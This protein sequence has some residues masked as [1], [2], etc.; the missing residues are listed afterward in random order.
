M[1]VY[2]VT[3]N[4]RTYRIELE[5]ARPSSS[6]A[7][8]EQKSAKDRTHESQWKVLLDG[9]QLLV[10]CLRVSNDSLSLIV[11]G[12]SIEARFERKGESQQILTGGRTYECSVRDPRSFRSRKRSGSADAGEQRITAS[13]PGKVVRV[14]ARPGDSLAEGQGIL[15]IEAMKMQN[16][17]RTPKAGVLKSLITRE[18][19]NVN[20]G[21]VLG[22]IE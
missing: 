13:M 12:E 7:P 16:E 4:G 1:I 15:I 20:A 6:A 11:N 5:A 10:N 8:A 21:E 19:A 22:I 18:G 14:L 2:E 17:V 3:L 9:R